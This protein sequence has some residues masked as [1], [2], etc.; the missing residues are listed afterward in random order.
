MSSPLMELVRLSLLHRLLIEFTDPSPQKNPVSISPLERRGEDLSSAGPVHKLAT[1]VNGAY[2]LDHSYPVNDIRTLIAND[3]IL[4]QYNIISLCAFAMPWATAIARGAAPHRFILLE[5]KLNDKKLWLKLERRPDSKIALLRGFG[6][7]TARDAVRS[8][9]TRD[10]LGMT[11]QRSFAQGQFLKH[12][13]E[14]LFRKGYRQENE[15]QLESPH[16][17]LRDLAIVID[18]ICRQHPRY[19]LYM[20]S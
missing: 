2:I 10:C 15:Y 14:I 4:A 11:C 1:E 19:T 12:N 16:P 3:P 13:R 18:V 8:G 6:R 9:V 20:V 7:T 17:T 5:L